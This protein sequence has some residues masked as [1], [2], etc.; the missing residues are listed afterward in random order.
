VCD[1]VILDLVFFLVVEVLILMCDGGL[2]F[3][4]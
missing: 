1:H 4:S 3:V 2:I